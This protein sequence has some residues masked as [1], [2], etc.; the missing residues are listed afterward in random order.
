M[1]LLSGGHLRSGSSHVDTLGHPILH[2]FVV[3]V[4]GK[5]EFFGATLLKETEC[6]FAES[7]PRWIILDVRGL[8]LKHLASMLLLLV[9]IEEEG[10]ALPFRI[11]HNH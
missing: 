2:V 1:Q 5:W 7:G 11:C 6:S 3:H 9:Q 4:R 10:I 8:K